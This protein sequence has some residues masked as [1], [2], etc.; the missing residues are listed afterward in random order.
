MFNHLYHMPF[1]EI[2]SE[3]F[4]AK[5]TVAIPSFN[6]G[7]YLNEALESIFAQQLP[8]EV[9]LA[10][11][12]SND[13]TVAI[14]EHWQP[15]L[16]WWRSS[17]DAGQSAAINEAIAQGTAPYVCWLNADDR[18]CQGGLIK[19]LNVLKKR[20]D[21]PAAYGR[22][23]NINSV[24]VRLNHYWT[25]PFSRWRLAQHCFISQPTTLIRRSIWEALGGLDET[26]DMAM[27]YDLWWRIYKKYGE[28]A[29]VSAVIAENRLHNDTKTATR[30]RQHYIEAMRVV[31]YHYGSIPLKW[32][33]M[34]PWSVWW[35][36]R[37]VI[38]KK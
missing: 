25:G 28:P 20:P 2:M 11:A 3:A 38:Q 18:Y 15:R 14:I 9:M 31:K 23:W 33:L 36:S 34:W 30:R 7:R 29:F 10:D 26:L 17:A 8:V 12:G 32:Y 22:S 6:H 16:S 24:G 35:R 19:L 27:D 1:K 13:E 4:G 37:Q 21:R 5:I